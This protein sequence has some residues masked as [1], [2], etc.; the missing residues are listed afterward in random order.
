MCLPNGCRFQE[1]AAQ[2]DHLVK[3]PISLNVLQGSLADPARSGRKYSPNAR[4][5]RARFSNNPS[6]PG[7]RNATSA[8]ARETAHLAVCEDMD[9][10]PNDKLVKTQIV[11]SNRSGQAR[12]SAAPFAG[13]L[14]DR[15]RV[16]LRNE[17][18]ADDLSFNR[19]LP[20]YR[21]ARIAG[22]F[23]LAVRDADQRSSRP[24]AAYPECSDRRGS[25][26]RVLALL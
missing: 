12:L 11:Q 5:L 2:H 25:R 4:V 17:Q 16:R 19:R 3:C 23:H 15:R 6:R 14:E 21:S 8:S 26:V 13:E 9:G 10:A 22:A 7:V 1:R 20:R 24:A 18:R